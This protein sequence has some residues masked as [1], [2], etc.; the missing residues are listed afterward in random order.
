MADND[1]AIDG[2]LMHAAESLAQGLIFASALFRPDKII[3]GGGI[4]A[5]PERYFTTLLR[6]FERRAAS[7]IQEKTSIERSTLGERS[8]ILGIAAMGLDEFIFK[9]S[10][11]D[12]LKHHQGA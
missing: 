7:I 12:Q 3:I 4:S 1:S 5:L 11:L 8:G 6:T 9:R 10:L 2:E